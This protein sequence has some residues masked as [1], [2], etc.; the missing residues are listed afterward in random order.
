M[1]MKKRIY[2]FTCFQNKI[3]F[4]I[5]VQSSQP[6]FYP[7]IL[8]Q[9][10]QNILIYFKCVLLSRICS[11]RNFIDIVLKCLLH[12]IADICKFLDKPLIL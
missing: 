8:I 9:L 10:F 4:I 7:Q 12:Y 1:K 11:C 5:T 3:F 2:I 6:K